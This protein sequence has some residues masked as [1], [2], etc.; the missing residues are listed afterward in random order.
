MEA[1]NQLKTMRND[2]LSRLQSNTDY[3]LLT[4]LDNLIV[5]LETMS[6]NIRPKFMIVDDAPEDKTAADSSLL[7]D[8]DVEK[9]FGNLTSEL[10]DEE[11]DSEETSDK[12]V[13]SFS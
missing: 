10:N 1:I 12:P 11:T 5:D 2:A 13:V 6:R 7:S 4:S 3:R 8:S 9:A